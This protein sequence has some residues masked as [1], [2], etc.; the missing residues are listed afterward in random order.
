VRDEYGAET[1]L[2]AVVQFDAIGVLIFDIYVVT[3]ENPTGDTNS[4]KLV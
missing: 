1:D 4:A 2:R 3:D